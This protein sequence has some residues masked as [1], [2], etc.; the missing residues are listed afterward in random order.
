L[1][2]R[3]PRYVAEEAGFREGNTVVLDVVAQG[4]VVI[5]AAARLLTIDELTA[6]ITPENLHGEERWGEPVGAEAW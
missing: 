3:I 4:E 5:R 6:K 1:A 2:I